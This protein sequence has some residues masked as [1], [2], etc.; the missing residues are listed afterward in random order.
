MFIVEN[1][2][3]VRKVLSWRGFRMGEIR[4]ATPGIRVCDGK[5]PEGNPFSLEMIIK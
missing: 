3:A 5:D 4:E 2:E 1:I